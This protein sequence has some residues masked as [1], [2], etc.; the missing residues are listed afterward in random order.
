MQSLWVRS[1]CL[2][3]CVCV[4]VV[5]TLVSVSLNPVFL[6]LQYCKHIVSN[7][8][9][10]EYWPK[11]EKSA[12]IKFLTGF[13]IAIRAFI[14]ENKCWKWILTA[15]FGWQQLVLWNENFS[16][17]Q[18]ICLKI[19]FGDSLRPITSQIYTLCRDFSIIDHLYYKLGNFLLINWYI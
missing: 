12:P 14:L 15:G 8:W 18:L 5:D 17:K 2:H 19:M 1:A 9:N 4:C 7:I 6:V 16:F 3:L 13:R 11:I 10:S